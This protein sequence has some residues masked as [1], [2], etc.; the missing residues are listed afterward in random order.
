MVSTLGFPPVDLIRQSPLPCR[1]QFFE[2]SDGDS[3]LLQHPGTA[4]N[5]TAVDYAID[6]SAGMC[7]DGSK[8]FC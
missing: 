1:G 3:W 7:D 6:A 8:I 4:S 2:P 5:Q